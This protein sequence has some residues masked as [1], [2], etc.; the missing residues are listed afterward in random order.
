M[1]KTMKLILIS[2]LI[3]VSLFGLYKWWL[4]GVREKS[5]RDYAT[6]WLSL[7]DKYPHKGQEATSGY[8]NVDKYKKMYEECM[9]LQG[10]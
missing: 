7:D 3:V 4:H 1:T 6:A 10:Y 9:F 5:C 2:V 8:K